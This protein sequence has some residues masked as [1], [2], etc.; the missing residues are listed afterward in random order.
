MIAENETFDD[1]TITLDGST[2]KGCS[3]NRC[4]LVYSGSL[5]VV[6][7]DCKFNGCKYNFA[8]GASLTVGFMSLLYQFGGGGRDLIEATFD[9]IRKGTA[10]GRREAAGGT[11]NN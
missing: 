1:L 7:N 5:P 9:S 2:F 4:T 8:G 3:F 10:T 6:L 11:G